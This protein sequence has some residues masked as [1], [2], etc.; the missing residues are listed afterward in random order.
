MSSIFGVRLCKVKCLD[1]HQALAVLIKS[2]E[3]F[4]ILWINWIVLRCR[5][6]LLWSMQLHVYILKTHFLNISFCYNF[7][8]MDSAH[9]WTYTNSAAYTL[10]ICD[11]DTLHIICSHHRSQS[12]N[13][14]F[15]Q[16]GK[17][18]SIHPLNWFKCSVYKNVTGCDFKMLS[19]RLQCLIWVSQLLKPVSITTILLKTVCATFNMHDLC[20][21][22]VFITIKK[23]HLSY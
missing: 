23:L 4:F 16:S 9:R 11:T 1:G 8:T 13:I 15:C 7:R 2:W 18:G 21:L 5:M 14:K 12:T 19:Y 17:S 6:V 3:L 22:F 20:S 10:T